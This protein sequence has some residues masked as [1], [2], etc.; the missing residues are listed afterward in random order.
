MKLKMRASFISMLLLF[1]TLVL[2][3]QNCSQEG[4][5]DLFSEGGGGGPEIRGSNTLTLK[6]V[7]SDGQEII[8]LN[9]DYDNAIGAVLT[10]GIQA[11]ANSGQKSVLACIYVGGSGPNNC[12]GNIPSNVV[13]LGNAAGCIASGG[14]REMDCMNEPRPGLADWVKATLANGDVRYTNANLFDVLRSEPGQL[15]PCDFPLS[16]TLY[17]KPN[18][19]IIDEQ[20]VSTRVRVFNLTLARPA[21]CNR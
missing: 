6:F 11:P 9:V 12:L 14:W 21:R 15:L 17:V 3:Y 8:P 13:P 20:D 5:S 2:F 16:F 7:N 19:G 1:F 4:T 18:N 10:S